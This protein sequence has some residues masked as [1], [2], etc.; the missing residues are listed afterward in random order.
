MDAVVGNLGPLPAP[1]AAMLFQNEAQAGALPVVVLTA[2]AA[3]PKL[4]LILTIPGDLNPLTA[5]L[6]D[7]RCESIEASVTKAAVLLSAS[8]QSRLLHLCV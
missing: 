2:A 1:V 5:P 6:P 3:C 4:G 8:G 7:E